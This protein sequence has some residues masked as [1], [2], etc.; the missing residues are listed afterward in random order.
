MTKTRKGRQ[1]RKPAPH[2]SPLSTLR[3]RLDR[4]FGDPALA[5]QAAQA[6]KADLDASLGGLEPAGF[7]PVL[8]KAA[9][10]APP[11]VQAQLNRVVPEWLSDRGLAAPLLTLLQGRRIAA[12]DEALARAWLQ[13]AGVEPPEVRLQAPASQ[14]YRAFG[15]SGAS[16]GFLIILWYTD[17][18]RRRVRGI[19]FL[20]D[21]NPPWDGALKDCEVF[22]QRSPQEAIERFVDYWKSQ[23]GIVPEP[24]GPAEAKAR[25]LKS[26]EANRR[27]D[28]RLPRDVVRARD[29]L[30][31]QVLSLPDLP[32]AAP[33]TA[34]DFDR[35]ASSGQSAEEI[36]HFEH[37]VGRRVRVSDGKEV[38][39]IGADDLDDFD[40]E[41]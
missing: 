31:G 2:P 40:D 8:L 4:L 12:D 35:L 30:L 18:R 15:Y 11:P 33:F 5:E 32:G 27:Q 16:Q 39:I 1:A 34:A 22:P 25:L 20:I 38:L 10:A 41:E 37:A 36:S 26:L 21:F 9:A 17:D 13:A 14:F 6:V 23:L 29:L 7:L 28:I 24:L 19:T 3:P